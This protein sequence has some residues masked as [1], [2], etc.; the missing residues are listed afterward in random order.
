MGSPRQSPVLFGPL[1]PESFEAQCELIRSCGYEGMLYGSNPYRNQPGGIGDAWDCHIYGDHPEGPKFWNTYWNGQIHNSPL[2]PPGIPF[3]ATEVGQIW[4]AA[5]RG[6]SECQIYDDLIA[7][8]CRIVLPF[9][10]ATDPS[11]YNAGGKIDRDR[12]A[13]ANDPERMDA[14]QYLVGKCIGVPYPR[15]TGVP[16]FKATQIDPWVW[17]EGEG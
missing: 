15:R 7:K 1:G 2:P 13:F 5:T 17:M 6:D 8:G 14:F 12:Y 10:L 11:D 4:P 9:A 3:I 16:G